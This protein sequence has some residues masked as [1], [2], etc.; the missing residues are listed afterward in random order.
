MSRRLS[1]GRACGRAQ[2]LQVSSAAAVLTP[3]LFSGAV[4]P[5]LW[6]P[7]ICSFLHSLLP[8]HPGVGLLGCPIDTQGIRERV[9]SRRPVGSRDGRGKAGDTSDLHNTGAHLE[10]F[11]CDS[12]PPGLQFSFS[13]LSLYMAP[14]SAPFWCSSHNLLATSLW[15]LVPQ[16]PITICFSHACLPREI[17][18]DAKRNWSDTQA[19]S[20]ALAANIHSRPGMSEALRDCWRVARRMNKPFF[21][22]CRLVCILQGPAQMT[23][24]H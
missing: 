14:S 16:S 24:P 12:A 17:G 4:H 18:G 21:S 23:L 15:L 7:S 20:G 13:C 2:C 9:E 5:T 19:L 6:I 1:P 10:G 8:S 3:R 22:I 11:G